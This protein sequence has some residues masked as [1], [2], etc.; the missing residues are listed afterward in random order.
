[1]KKMTLAALLFGLTAPLMA[2]APAAEKMEAKPAMEAPKPAAEPKVEM[3]MMK[4]TAKKSKKMMKKAV[5][6][7]AKTPPAA[8]VK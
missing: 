1:M 7:E 8:E 4:K 3:K 2:Q 6:M 5:K